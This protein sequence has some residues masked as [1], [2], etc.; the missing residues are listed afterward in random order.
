MPGPNR[1]SNLGAD[2]TK[3]VRVG[4][5]VVKSLACHNENAAERYLQLHNTATTPTAGDVPVFSF[6]VP[7]L[8]MIVI[9]SDFFTDQGLLICTQTG[10]PVG[11]A[12]AFSTTKDTYTAATAADHST[13]I[14][15]N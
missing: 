3:N 5:T 4:P 2:A 13:W 12:F 14:N 15:Y 1:F 6:L 11:C 9:G 7:T 8:A 10:I